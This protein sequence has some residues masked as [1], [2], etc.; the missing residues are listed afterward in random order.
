MR[1]ILYIYIYILKEKKSIYIDREKEKD[2]ERGREKER[3]IHYTLV[4][5]VYISLQFIRLES[6]K[7]IVSC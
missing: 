6:I 3:K 2:T 1:E 5:D 7:R 4:V